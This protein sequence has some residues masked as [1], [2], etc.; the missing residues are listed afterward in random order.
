MCAFTILVRIQHQ[1]ASMLAFD[2]R[3]IVLQLICLHMNHSCSRYNSFSF[4]AF[5]LSFC[6]TCVCDAHGVHNTATMNP[7][8]HIMLSKDSL[9][10][11]NRSK[12]TTVYRLLRFLLFSYRMLLLFCFL[13][14][15]YRCVKLFSLTLCTNTSKSK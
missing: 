12:S 14:S 11:L 3:P 2:V 1:A 4:Q 9:F 7:K 5:S 15:F 10:Y 13:Y 6:G 8:T